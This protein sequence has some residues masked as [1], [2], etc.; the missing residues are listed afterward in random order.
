MNNTNLANETEDSIDMDINLDDDLDNM[1]TS[2]DDTD[3]VEIALADE[4][5]A[6]IDESEPIEESVRV[7]IF[8]INNE[9]IEVKE[10]NPSSEEENSDIVQLDDIIEVSDDKPVNLAEDNIIQLDDDIIEVN[11]DETTENQTVNDEEEPIEIN[12]F[13]DD[14]IIEVTENEKVTD[15]ETP[16]TDEIAEDNSVVEE[17]EVIEVDVIDKV[18]E[19]NSVIEQDEV[20]ESDII[21]AEISLTDD[22]I[23]VTD[24]DDIIEIEL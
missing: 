10:D 24:E 4:T 15:E 13:D 16:L 12:L 18:T 7:N 19:N 20:L 5:F 2:V 9:P 22:I 21:E 14:N 17:D 23:S 8:A 11:E 1:V 6:K 3:K